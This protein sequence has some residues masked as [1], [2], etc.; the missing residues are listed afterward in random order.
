M[1][2]KRCLPVIRIS[3]I[4]VALV[5]LGVVLPDSVEALMKPGLN[6]SFKM[7][8]KLHNGTTSSKRMEEIRMVALH[9]NFVHDLTLC[10]RL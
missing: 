2:R 7:N 6:T 3:L 8:L 5:H 9:I 4:N 10:F 1:F